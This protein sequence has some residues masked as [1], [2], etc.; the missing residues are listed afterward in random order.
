M[1]AGDL[2]LLR[3][4]CSV[5]SGELATYDISPVPGCRWYKS[6]HPTELEKHLE[7]LS[8]PFL[9]YITLRNMKFLALALAVLPAVLAQGSYSITAYT[10]PLCDSTS[11]VIETVSG[12]TNSTCIQFPGGRSLNLHMSGSCNRMTAFFSGDCTPNVGPSPDHTDI[13]SPW[14]VGCQ[15]YA[16]NAG[17]PNSFNSF[18][19][20]C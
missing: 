10:L 14:D 13:G 15:T 17:Q 7:H 18:K 16:L 8:K 6:T 12:P 1:T 4:S 19:V 9:N 11:S 5:C 3:F 20:F 2:F